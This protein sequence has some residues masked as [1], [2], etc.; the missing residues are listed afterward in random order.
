MHMHAH[1]AFQQSNTL[2][3]TLRAY[4][5]LRLA[6]RITHR[7]AAQ[8]LAVNPAAAATMASRRA[9]SDR[10]IFDDQVEQGEWR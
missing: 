7:L 8:R 5:A 10:G 1:P 2:K 3:E 4:M 6:L 9:F